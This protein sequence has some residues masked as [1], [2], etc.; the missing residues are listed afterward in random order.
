MKEEGISSS[1]NEE[2]GLEWRAEKYD[3][4]DV[5]KDDNDSNDDDD[6]DEYEEEEDEDELMVTKK[7]TMTI[8]TQK[9]K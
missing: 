9:V 5:N 8:K 2:E 7:L 1:S 3:K 4:D 6:D